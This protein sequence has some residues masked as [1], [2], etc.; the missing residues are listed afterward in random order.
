MEGVTVDQADAVVEESFLKKKVA[1]NLHGNFVIKQ[2][3]HGQNLYFSFKCLL[4]YCLYYF[5]LFN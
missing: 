3:Y 5:V 1:A 4:Y 2:R